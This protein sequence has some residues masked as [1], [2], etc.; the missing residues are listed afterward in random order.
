MIPEDQRRLVEN[1]RE[2]ESKSS[3]EF[4]DFLRKT[5][6]SDLSTFL[7]SVDQSDYS[8]RDWIDAMQAFDRWLAGRDVRERPFDAMT[9]Y[10]TCCTMTNPVSVQIPELQA[11]VIQNL[12]Q[13]GFEAVS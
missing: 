4:L 13:Y 9:G 7:E 6:V 5:G 3:R 2:G 1:A 12:E 11:V 10:I 8:L